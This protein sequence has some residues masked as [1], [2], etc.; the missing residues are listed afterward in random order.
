MQ[1]KTAIALVA[2]IACGCASGGQ[3]DSTAEV[4]SAASVELVVIN[5]TSDAIS[6]FARWAA[7][8]PTHLG[9]VGAGRTRTFTTAFRGGVVSLRVEQVAPTSGQRPSPFGQATRIFPGRVPD[10]AA[11]DRFE[12]RV[13]STFPL[14]ELA[15]RRLPS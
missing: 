1:W 6:A 7:G 5:E 14:I 9:E 3:M 11:G 12:W 8:R 13:L 2:V 4:G 15:F 10:A